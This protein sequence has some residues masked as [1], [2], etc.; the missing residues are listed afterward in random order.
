M[1]AE[2]T[3]DG[4]WSKVTLSGRRSQRRS[5]FWLLFCAT[6]LKNSV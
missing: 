5:R 4:T 2:R 3:R 1:Q 6:W